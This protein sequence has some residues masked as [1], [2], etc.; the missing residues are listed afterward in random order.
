MESGTAKRS[1]DTSASAGAY[2]YNEHYH[3]SWAMHAALQLFQLGNKATCGTLIGDIEMGVW[4]G[5]WTIRGTC[6]IVSSCSTRDDHIEEHYAVVI[7]RHG[8]ITPKLEQESSP[9]SSAH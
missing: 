7:D 1:R 3:K 8:H 2:P 4:A 5:D 6:K 9:F